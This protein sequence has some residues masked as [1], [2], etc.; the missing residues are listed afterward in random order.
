MGAVTRFL[1][2]GRLVLAAMGAAVLAPTSARAQDVTAADR[3]TFDIPAQ[4]LDAALTHY[5]R[6]TGVQLLY[7]SKLTAGAR[8]SAVRGLYS[9]REALRLLL[10]GTGLVAR[11]SRAS[12]AIITKAETDAPLVPL[13]RVVVR[14]Q[15][16]AVR[17]SPFERKAYYSRLESELKA[18]LSADRRTQ[19]M[20]FATRLS[21]RVSEAGAVSDIQI[22]H[23]SGDAKKDRLIA[24]VLL[25]RAV[26]PPPIGVEQ[27][28]LVIVKGHRRDED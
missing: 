18:Y 26:S 19:R 21:L 5:F 1:L 20:S 10:R 22:D 23:G 2:P 24:A 3:V 16:A 17:L 25:G 14:E 8:S 4:P 28:L 11:Y 6:R 15:I 27:P 7:D 13:G 12:A 9:P